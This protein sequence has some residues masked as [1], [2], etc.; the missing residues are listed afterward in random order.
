MLHYPL[1]TLVKKFEYIEEYGLHSTQRCMMTNIVSPSPDYMA[2]KDQ[3]STGSY[4]STNNVT[5]N[6]GKVFAKASLAY[7]PEDGQHRLTDIYYQAVNIPN[8]I[9]F[10]PNIFDGKV[11]TPHY[12]KIIQILVV[13]KPTILNILTQRTNYPQIMRMMKTG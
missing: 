1:D 3:N 4:P 2:S 9:Y 10:M 11:E 12:E 13:L 6:V 5:T 8:S 7:I